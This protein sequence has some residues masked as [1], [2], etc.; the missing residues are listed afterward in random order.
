MGNAVTNLADQIP[1]SIQSSDVINGQLVAIVRREAYA[2]T[3]WGPTPGQA[4]GFAPVPTVP[5]AVSV[6]SFGVLGSQ[7]PGYTANLGGTS[8]ATN[9][10]PGMGGGNA[11]AATAAGLFPWNWKLSPV[12][13]AIVLLLGALILMRVVH[14]K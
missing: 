5:P 10:G 7:G 1:W 12:P 3:A 8:Q 11:A 4:S 9:A 2:P 14:W 6:A 13:W